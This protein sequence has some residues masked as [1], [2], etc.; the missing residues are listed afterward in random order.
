[1]TLD[2]LKRLP[3]HLEPFAFPAL[4]LCGMHLPT[5]ILANAILVLPA[6][7]GL[8]IPPRGWSLAYD[9]IGYA[10][11]EGCEDSLSACVREACEVG[12]VLG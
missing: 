4:G 1:M 11:R 9:R 7:L 2:I 10:A 8:E 3:T 6:S 5:A 12:R